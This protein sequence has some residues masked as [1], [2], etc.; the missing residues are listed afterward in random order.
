MNVPNWII[1]SYGDILEP[2]IILQEELITIGTNGQ[3]QVHSRL[4]H[5][6]FSLPKDIS[7]AHFGL[8]TIARMF[9]ITFPPAFLVEWSVSAITNLLT[10]KF[11]IVAFVSEATSHH[12]KAY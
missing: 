12:I 11:H 2:N 7:V 8:R 5:Q 4:G 10:K 6:Q 1:D 9:M 3:L